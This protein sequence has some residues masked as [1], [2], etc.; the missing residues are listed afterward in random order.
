MS[1]VGPAPATAR[2][3]LGPEPGEGGQ[4]WY[5]RRSVLV[6]A[7]V[8]VV[9]VVTVVIDLPQH[10]SRS[11]QISSDSSVIR[12]VSADVGP[13]A[14]AVA[15]VFTIYGDKLSS[16]LTPSDA[17]RA[18]SLLRDDQ[19]A[20]SFTDQSI[21]NLANIEVPGSAAGRHLQELVSTVTL[22]A[23]SDG[24]A[25]IEAVQSLFSHPSDGAARRQLAMA[26]SELTHDRL[27]AMA[28]IAAANH[29]LRARLPALRLPSPFG[30]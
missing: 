30:A 15:E 20:C 12:Q 17:A 4:T 16:R 26:T 11:A 7:L 21:F 24:L 13:C 9:L 3:A 10:A 22:W 23:T 27:Q 5:R 2:A 18:P 8:M 19:N 25:A 28:E 29:V 14:Y 6:A 1:D